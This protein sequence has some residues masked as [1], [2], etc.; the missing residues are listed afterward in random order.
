MAGFE[1]YG[2]RKLATALN[3]LLSEHKHLRDRLALSK[4]HVTQLMDGNLSRNLWEALGYDM[5]AYI[6]ETRKR[7]KTHADS[8]QELLRTM[9]NELTKEI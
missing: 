7:L 8:E 9:R 2:D 3:S 5:R 4:E 1:K 6:S